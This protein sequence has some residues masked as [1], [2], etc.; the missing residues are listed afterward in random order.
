MSL[1]SHGIRSWTT[2]MDRDPNHISALGFRI[3][4]TTDL[5]VRIPLPVIP[6]ES[7][8]LILVFQQHAHIQSVDLIYA[9]MG[10]LGT[11][12]RLPWVGTVPIDVAI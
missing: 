8:D 1:N 4:S 2:D 7:G 11:M 12:G 5:S 3:E 9:R 6:G 10:S